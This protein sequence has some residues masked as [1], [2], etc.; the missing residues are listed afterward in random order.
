ML[1]RLAIRSSGDGVTAPVSANANAY[2]IT[3]IPLSLGPVLI[4]RLAQMVSKMKLKEMHLKVY[5]ST[6]CSGAMHA[7]GQDSG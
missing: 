1:R 4:S 6:F 3:V 7:A 2:S 5:H